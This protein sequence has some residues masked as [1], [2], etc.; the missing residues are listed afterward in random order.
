MIED[1]DFWNRIN[2]AGNS[3]NSNQ[4]RA[5]LMERFLKS[6]PK[7]LTIEFNT[8]INLVNDR[9]RFLTASENVPQSTKET[10][11][12]GTYMGDYNVVTFKCEVVARGRRERC[13]PD[14][15]KKIPVAP[16][17]PQWR[18]MLDRILDRQS[19]SLYE[20][21]SGRMAVIVH[22]CREQNMVDHLQFVL[23][24]RGDE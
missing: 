22:A 23:R 13:D 24:P 5:V 14:Q 16:D 19:C 4:M 12:A 8:F 3:R 1:G 11:P 20:Q 17:N 9:E 2:T 21:R 15:F 18:Q 10:N 7:R 6:E